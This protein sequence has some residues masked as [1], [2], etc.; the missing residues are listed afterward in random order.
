MIIHSAYFLKLF[1]TKVKCSI[2]YVIMFMPLGKTFIL[3]LD[4]LNGLINMGTIIKYSKEK[5]LIVIA[6]TLV[7]AVAEVAG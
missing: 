4:S 3:L 2:V 5:N 7:G 6:D 1:S